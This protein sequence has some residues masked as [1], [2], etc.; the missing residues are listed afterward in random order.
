M[1]VIHPADVS[2]YMWF[3]AR[4]RVHE[5]TVRELAESNQFYYLVIDRAG[6]LAG[7]W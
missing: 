7:A 5:M 1:P 6:G 4:R 2:S 3:Y